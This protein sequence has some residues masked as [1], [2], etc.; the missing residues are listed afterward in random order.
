MI[1]FFSAAYFFAKTGKSIPGASLDEFIAGSEKIQL[2]PEGDHAVLTVVHD[3]DSFCGDENCSCGHHHHHDDAVLPEGLSLSEENIS[4]PLKLLSEAG[5]PLSQLELDG[6]MLDAIYGRETDFD[7]VR[8]R[9]F[10]HAEF[11]FEDDEE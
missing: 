4:D 6:F 2:R 7:G 5:F 8:S 3:D 11:D 9:I 10:G 1:Q